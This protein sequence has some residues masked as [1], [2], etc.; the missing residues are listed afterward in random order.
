[1][2]RHLVHH[3][4]RGLHARDEFQNVLACIRLLFNQGLCGDIFPRRFESWLDPLRASGFEADIRAAFS[5][6][7]PAGGKEARRFAFNKVR[8]LVG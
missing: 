6:P 2:A 5:S 3:S 8:L 4:G 7:I 1:M